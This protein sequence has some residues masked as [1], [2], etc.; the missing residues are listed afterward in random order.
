LT[1]V[2]AFSTF[3]RSEGETRVTLT[4]AQGAKAISKFSAQ[5]SV[6]SAA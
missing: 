4:V 3:S 5:F 1:D 6:N 2:K